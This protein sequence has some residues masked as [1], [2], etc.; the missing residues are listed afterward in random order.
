LGHGKDYKY[1]HN[2]EGHFVEQEYMLEKIKY[3]FPTE[4]GYEK[5]IKDRMDRLFGPKKLSQSI[6]SQ[7]DTLKNKGVLG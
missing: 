6:N 7:R 2:Y 1:A 4:I 3:Y 5:K